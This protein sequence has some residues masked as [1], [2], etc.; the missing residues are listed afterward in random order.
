MSF[1]LPT[2]AELLLR[3]NAGVKY[4]YLVLAAATVLVLLGRAILT[5]ESSPLSQAFTNFGKFF[6]AS[7]LKPH[8]G[9]GKHTGQQAALESFYKAQVS[10]LFIG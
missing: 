4:L 9:D 8:A 6:Y 1:S 10:R 7:F 5:L 3:P 2:A